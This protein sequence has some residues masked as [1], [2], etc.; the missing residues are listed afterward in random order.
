M[1]TNKKIFKLTNFVPIGFKNINYPI[2][3]CLLCRGPLTE[4]CH[5]CSEKNIENCPVEEHNKLYYHKHCHTLVKNDQKD[6]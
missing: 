4:V 2:D 6:Q 1:A 5:T 3:M